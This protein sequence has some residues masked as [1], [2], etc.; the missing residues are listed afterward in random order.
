MKY[1]FYMDGQDLMCEIYDETFRLA[2]ANN[3]IITFIEFGDLITAYIV[4]EILDAAK[5]FAE[6][7]GFKINV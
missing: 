5:E 4:P 3:D 1:F 2:V 7:N 6:N